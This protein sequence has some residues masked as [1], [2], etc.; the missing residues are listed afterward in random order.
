MKGLPSGYNK[1]LQEDK[2]AVFD[3]EATLGASLRAT[4]AVISRLAFNADRTERAASGLLLA[5]DVADYLVARGM[6]FRRAHEV[7]GA[8]VRRLLAEGRD[9]ST[10]TLA[11]WR[12][13]SELV[14]RRCAA[15]RNRARFR[16]GTPDAP[17]DQPGGSPSCARGV[18]QLGGR[19]SAV[20][21][22]VGVIPRA[23]RT[24]GSGRRFCYTLET[25]ALFH[26]PPERHGSGGFSWTV[27]TTGVLGTTGRQTR[28]LAATA[29]RLV[30]FWEDCTTNAA[31]PASAR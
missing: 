29:D 9:F 26:I 7:V 6:P 12:E 15:S 24:V 1:D 18:P 22:A 11:E 23:R 19:E 10:M 27:S 13:A 31:T 2:E 30:L 5:T 14:R 25:F 8:L 4:H 28:C 21:S 16:S 17:V 3:A 20:C